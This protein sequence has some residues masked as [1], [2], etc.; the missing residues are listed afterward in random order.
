MK[1]IKQG[2]LKPATKRITCENC[3]TIFEVEKKGRR[4]KPLDNSEFT[5][6]YVSGMA[7]EGSHRISLSHIK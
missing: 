5:T 7:D 3:G 6:Q 4:L 2:E 1:I